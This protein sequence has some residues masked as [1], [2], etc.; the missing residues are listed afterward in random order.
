MHLLLPQD[1]LLCSWHFQTADSNKAQTLRAG[2][3]WGQKEVHPNHAVPTKPQPKSRLTIEYVTQD[4]D[5]H[6]LATLWPPPASYH[7][8]NAP[9]FY[10]EN[11]G[12]SE[13]NFYIFN[14]GALYFL[15]EK[16]ASSLQKGEVEGKKQS[17]VEGLPHGED[18]SRDCWRKKKNMTMQVEMQELHFLWIPIVRTIYPLWLT[19]HNK[20]TKTEYK[21]PNILMC[22]KRSSKGLDCKQRRLC[23]K[24]MCHMKAVTSIA[25]KNHKGKWEGEGLAKAAHFK[26]VILL[27]LCHELEQYTCWRHTGNYGFN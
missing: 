18:I 12:I 20:A 9:H 4:R 7:R 13:V 17:W 27:S 8:K 24:F 21:P 6:L 19:R 15:G 26:A 2:G 3:F 14:P 10:S 11:R 23:Q 5:L 16:N 25:P 22:E 1:E